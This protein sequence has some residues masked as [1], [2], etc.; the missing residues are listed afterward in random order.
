MVFQSAPIGMLADFA[1]PNAPSG[2]LIADGRAVS[3]TQFSALFAVIGGFY[4]AGD[5]STTFNLPNLN[6][7]SA[8]GPGTVIDQ[9]GNSLSLSFTQRIG[10]VWGLIQQTHL[11]NYNLVT[12]TQGWH[13]HA[14]QT[15][16]AGY[17]AH[18][19][20]AQGNHSHGGGTG[21]M[22]NDHYHYAVTDTQGSHSHFVNAW[23]TA[24]GGALASGAVPTQGGVT[25]STDG[26][27]QHSF[28][29]GGVSANHYHAISADGNH[30]HNVYAVGDHVHGIY[31]DGNHQ[32]NVALGGGGQW[33][34]VLN[35]IIVITKI[36]YAGQQAA[37]MVAAAAD[38]VPTTL[39]GRDELA[40]IREELAQLRAILAPPAPQRRLSAPLR[41]PN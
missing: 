30:T 31:G 17:H 21:W 37:T 10:Y 35:P 26:A 32:H 34:E 38:G 27:H 41:G 29:T 28:N 12:D 23:A 4:G 7:R 1:G 14:G 2:W 40:A 8:V 22:S 13:N 9:A 24:G 25:T 20:D 18:T 19:T 39:E 5:G 16:G 33:F 6:G 11:P 3:R 36:I 15:V